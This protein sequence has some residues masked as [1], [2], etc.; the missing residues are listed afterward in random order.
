MCFPQRDS[1]IRCP[2]VP[3]RPAEA[4]AGAGPRGHAADWETGI[5]AISD[6]WSPG[7]GAFR[8]LL[9][10]AVVVSHLSALDVGLPAV[11]VFFMLSGYWVAAIHEDLRREFRAGPQALTIFWA[12][13]GLRIFLPFA[14]AWLLVAL[15][16][17][18]SGHALPRDHRGLF[19][20]GLATH[21]QDLLSISWSL[22]IELQFYLLAPPLCWALR[23]HPAWLGVLSPALF[24]AG[25]QLQAMGIVTVAAF[26][27]PFLCGGALWRW[28]A[29][30]L[31]LCPPAVGAAS[32]ALFLAAGL[33]T[34]AMPSLQPLLYKGR[35][36]PI[37]VEL[38]GMLWTLLLAPFLL[39]N[40]QRRS[41]RLDRHLG[42]YSYSLYLVHFALFVVLRD[43]PLAAMPGFKPLAAAAGLLA[44]LAFYL[45]VD[46]PCERLRARAVAGLRSWAAA[47]PPPGPAPPS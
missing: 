39:R 8:V 47:G 38:F 37:P 33:G 9:A 5:R 20:L 11:M 45:L 36:D 46:R 19:L 23:R 27:I 24:W 17:A 7:P 6:R 32:V 34:W 22:D 35:P 28:R 3:I 21:G 42:N 40:L 18:W 25:L 29:G 13:R 12:S 30:L 31:R 15:L 1:G 41:G 44:G 10:L 16:F 14:A 2:R 26:A 4:A 43:T